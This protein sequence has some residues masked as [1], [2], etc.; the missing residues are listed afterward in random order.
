[1]ASG[2]KRTEGASTIT[3]QLLKNNV[4]D[5]MSE[6]SMAEKVERKLQEQYLAVKLEE[7]MTKDEILESYLN[8]INLGQNSLGVQAASNRYF[9]K[10][11]SELTLSEAA[12]LAATTKSPTA[13]NP[14]SHPKDNADRRALVLQNMLDQGYISQKKYE[15]AIEDDVYPGSGTI[16]RSR[17]PSARSIPI[18][19]TK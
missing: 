9:G 7:V 4:F 17:R 14:I 10:N 12:V 1:M 8:T 5:F 2:F 15:E 6:S 3:Q 19:T 13:Y 16:T 18:L 11:V